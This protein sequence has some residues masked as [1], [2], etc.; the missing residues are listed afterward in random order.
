MDLSKILRTAFFR[1]GGVKHH[2]SLIYSGC[3]LG[4]NDQRRSFLYFAPIMKYLRFPDACWLLAASRYFS[5]LSGVNLSRLY[6][7]KITQ[8]APFN[9]KKRKE[10][11]LNIFC[12][13]LQLKPLYSA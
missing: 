10:S 6:A 3:A 2:A 4:R 5:T 12:F 7:K 1:R 11:S 9:V 8:A 13:L